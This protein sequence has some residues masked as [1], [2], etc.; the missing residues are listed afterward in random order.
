M[1]AFTE[2]QVLFFSYHF[3]VV[4]QP[5]LFLVSTWT[6]SHKAAPLLIETPKLSE[7]LK[8]A[9]V[10]TT[11]SRTAISLPLNNHGFLTALDLKNQKELCVT[12]DDARLSIGCI[13]LMENVYWNHPCNFKNL[14]AVHYLILS[15]PVGVNKDKSLHSKW[16][17]EEQDFWV[18]TPSN[19]SVLKIFSDL[20]RPAFQNRSHKDL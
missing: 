18:S 8:V 15:A 11:I 3:E 9:A 17:Q 10:N 16:R 12:L 1:H 14:K 20:Q 13:I 4:L 2:M 6:S 7:V 19:Q 5:L